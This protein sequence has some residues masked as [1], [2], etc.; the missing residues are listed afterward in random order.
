MTT[1]DVITR[2]FG[3]ISWPTD[4][5][6]DYSPDWHGW[7]PP[8][9]KTAHYH[10]M[11]ADITSWLFRLKR[12]MLDY[13]ERQCWNPLHWFAPRPGDGLIIYLLV[14][15]GDLAVRVRDGRPG[16]RITRQGRH[17]L[18]TFRFTRA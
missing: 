7:E 3:Q 6:A 12:R 8:D 18:N 15:S 11:W 5:R 17:T 16:Y 13:A 9:P 14:K 2:H 1:A 10:D 4:Q